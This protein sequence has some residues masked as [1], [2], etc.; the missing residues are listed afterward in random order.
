M[1]LYE[2][3]LLVLTLLNKLQV[4]EMLF[5]CIHYETVRPNIVWKGERNKGVK[6]AR[7]AAIRNGP[8]WTNIC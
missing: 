3:N 8:K 2:L 7:L 1:I 6:T 5:L 4:M